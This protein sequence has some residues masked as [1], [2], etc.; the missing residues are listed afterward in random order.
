MNL[1]LKLSTISW[2]I[3]IGLLVSGLGYSSLLYLSSQDVSEVQLEVQQL[4]ESMD[5]GEQALTTQKSSVAAISNQL[6]QLYSRT[7]NLF[8]ITVVFILL[9]VVIMFWLLIYRMVKPIQAIEQVMHE[10][11][12]DGDF[13]KRVGL[14]IED[15]LGEMARV[16]DDLLGSL[17]D[18]IEEANGVV[19][20]VA[21]GDFSKRIETEYK[22]DL[23]ILKQGVNGS[24]SSVQTT[25]DALEEVMESLSEGD[26]NTKMDEQVEEQF[27]TMVDEAMGSVQKVIKQIVRVMGHMASGDFSQRVDIE[28][29][30]SL[31]VMKEAINASMETLQQAIQETV[32]TAN[33][34]GEGDLTQEIRGNYH[35]QLEEMKSAINGTSKNL[36]H[37]VSQVRL[38][39]QRVGTGSTEIS[40]GNQDLSSRTAEQAASLEETAASMEE[41]ASTV[42]MNAD[43]SMQ[44]NQL[45]AE[46][47]RQAEEGASVVKKA[48]AAMSEISDSSGRIS[49]ISSMID[50]IAFQ[51]N[52][53]ALN[54]AVEA[55]RAGEQGRG[56]AVVAGEVRTL[57]QRSADA[58]QE[59]TKLIDESSNRIRHGSDLVNQTGESLESIELSIKKV[60]DI[61]SEIA[62]AAQEQTSGINQVNTAV[63]E[64]DSVNQQNAALVEEAAAASSTLSDQ[65]DGLTSLVSF[66]NLSDELEQKTTKLTNFADIFMRAKAA[67]LAWK[68]KIRA[69]V[70]GTLSVD[71]ASKLTCEECELGNWIDRHGA[72]EYGAL[73]EMQELQASHDRMHQTIED[74][75]D[76]KRRGE[77]QK[78]QKR[79]QEI[80]EISELVIKRLD[81][82][83]QKINGRSVN[84]NT[85][86]EAV[87]Q[88]AA[89]KNRP[90][91]VVPAA[92]SSAPAKADSSIGGDSEWEDF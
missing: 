86:A 68:E 41:M 81:Q 90:R 29:D 35:G 8:V 44:A 20:A 37:V 84:G 26:F 34:M 5:Q 89:P 70:A 23:S 30:G 31:E 65:A 88:P 58:A 14:E 39:A 21:E 82:L 63:A 22:G 32:E 33:R 56:F 92:Q 7:S 57:A 38:T 55:A 48:V 87:S 49:E 11:E 13:S 12:L 72:A 25:M 36:A 73:K 42:K 19:T 51:T 74:I 83:E 24:A 1:N 85:Q 43:N 64:L 67:H 40:R 18:A 17:H 79:Y 15:E 46:S 78:A 27:R 69:V 4:S 50:G 6:E 71:G 61:A 60:N 76:F 9:A 16:F 66:F 10:V 52:L 59:I 77:D 47:S 53:L 80:E 3:V 45:S 91:T 75:L 62:A 54:A 2:A 28:V